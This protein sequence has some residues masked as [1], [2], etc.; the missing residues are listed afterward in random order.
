VREFDAG[1]K[2]TLRQD[3]A[4]L[5]Q[6]IDI[7]RQEEAWKFDRLVAR[8]QVELI[9]RSSRF[10]DFRTD[11]FNIVSSLRI[12]LSQVRVK[13]PVIEKV[14]SSEFW[15]NVTVADLEGI[16]KELRGIVQFRKFDDPRPAEPKIIDVKEDE[17]QIEL[18]RHKVRLDKLDGLDMVAYR[19]RVTNVLQAII[20]QSETLQKIK[21]GQPV[22]ET[23]L[24]DLCSL[25]LTQEP[26]LDLHNLA[27]Y[28]P[29]A[30]GLDRAIRGI[31]GMDAK[32]VDERFEAFIHAHPEI[33]SHANKF[34]QLL[35]QHI[36]KFGSIE[37]A[38][39]YEPPFTTLHSEGPDGLF[40]EPLVDEL[41]DIIGTFQ[42][43]GS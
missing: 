23:D 42:P 21:L 8:A 38:Q 12:N 40:E 34:L 29:Q 41:L 9:R 11:I 27:E 19:N 39:L 1:T 37:I 10:D 28:F 35:Q 17:S 25:V 31:I 4:P 22:S 30:G 2:A 16:R 7:T 3:I 13:L 36:A 24:E 15:D 26:G 32:A 20:D 5:M 14:K 43:Q 33:S 6:W 18:K